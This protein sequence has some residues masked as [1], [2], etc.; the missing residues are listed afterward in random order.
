MTE[1]PKSSG[2]QDGPSALT[3]SD[4]FEIL[5]LRRRRTILR[6]LAEQ[7][8]GTIDFRG[9]VEAVSTC[10]SETEVEEPAIEDRARAPRRQRVA[11]ALHH[12]DLLR[13]AEAGL[14]EYD[15]W[16]GEIRYNRD[17]RLDDWLARTVE[18]EHAQH[19][20]HDREPYSTKP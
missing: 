5:S 3:L 2:D 12:D 4:L 13:L 20:N 19:D 15:R 14:I 7:P 11:R 16:H 10:E 18:D 17:D 9:L 8:N 1:T 6:C